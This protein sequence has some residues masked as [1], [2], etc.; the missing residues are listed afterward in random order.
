MTRIHLVLPALTW[1]SSLEATLASIA[2]IPTS[3]MG[4]TII[5]AP[6]AQLPKISR[7]LDSWSLNSP[8]PRLLAET[9]KG[10]YPAFNNGLDALKGATGYVIFLGAGDCLNSPEPPLCDAMAADV[11]L[12]CL[13]TGGDPATLRRFPAQPWG[14][15][16][17]L[18]NSQ[19]CVFNLKLGA[20]LIYQERFAI[21]DDVLQRIAIL[22]SEPHTRLDCA[23]IVTIDGHGVSGVQTPGKILRHFSE[24]RA[25]FL[26]ILRLRQ[27]LLATK[28]LIGSLKD[29]VRYVSFEPTP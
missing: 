24:R 15:L 22:Q 28:Y 16:T 10:V 19:G 17:C 7:H 25:L 23:P 5:I 8:K 6:A 26:P 27:P 9:G 14:L 21:Y 1:D 4:Q 18:P 20:K 29:I 3:M 2:N 11:S 13:P 12:V